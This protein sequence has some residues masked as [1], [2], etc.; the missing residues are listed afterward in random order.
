MWKSVLLC[1]A[2]LI[3]V[4]GH[5]SLTNDDAHVINMALLGIASAI[6]PQ[7]PRLLQPL[8]HDWQP[9]NHI[10]GQAHLLGGGNGL[11]HHHRHH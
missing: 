3:F 9:A 6:G 10:A 1:F 2:Q 11:Q 4:D 5:L 7:N 8:A